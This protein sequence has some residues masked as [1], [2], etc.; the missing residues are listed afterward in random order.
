MDS[1]LRQ[2]LTCVSLTLHA[3]VPDTDLLSFVSVCV[4]VLIAFDNDDD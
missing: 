2:M 3:F 4:L 1:N